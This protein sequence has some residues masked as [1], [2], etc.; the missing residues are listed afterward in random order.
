MANV[1]TFVKSAAHKF[2]VYAT[3]NQTESVKNFINEEIK[4]M[5]IDEVKNVKF[6][7]KF[8]AV[9]AKI[10]ELFGINVYAYIAEEIFSPSVDAFNKKNSSRLSTIINK[11]NDKTIP[12]ATHVLF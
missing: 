2:K 12:I 6:Y 7:K 10:V 8:E 11:I 3:Q 5:L 1:K 4:P 9:N